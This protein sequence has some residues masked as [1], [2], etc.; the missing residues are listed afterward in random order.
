MGNRDLKCA[1]GEIK[2]KGEA[3]PILLV[4]IAFSEQTKDLV[5][6]ARKWV[7]QY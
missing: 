4:E 6:S 5:R 2:K 3:F 7:I 1:D